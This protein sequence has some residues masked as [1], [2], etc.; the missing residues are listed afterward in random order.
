[1]PNSN[2]EVFDQVSEAGVLAVLVIE[3][4]SK[5]APLAE[6][7]LEGGVRAMELTLRTPAALDAI[8]Q[9]RSEVPEMIVGAGTVL[10][11]EQI[12]EVVSVG[13]HFAVS[14]GLNR[15]T[16]Q[17][18]QEKGIPFAPGIVTPSEVEAALEFDCRVL[19]FFPCEASGGLPY[20]RNMAAP[21]KHLGLKYIPLGGVKQS[22]LAEY[23]SE[24][25]VAAVGGSWLAPS[26]AIASGDWQ[27][28]EGLAQAASDTVR[29]V[30]S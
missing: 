10:K 18:A 4:A 20:L 28:I 12:D 24:P 22:N 2:P 23:L 27:H 21:Y 11:P 29:E 5:A 16:M 30:R 25:L 9:V 15:R 3:D 8:R 13:A 17:A 26:D 1:M 19:K 6:A 14:P 7:L